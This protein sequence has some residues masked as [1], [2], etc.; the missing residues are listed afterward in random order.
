M[1]EKNEKTKERQGNVIPPYR[2][3]GTTPE[4]EEN[5]GKVARLEEIN[6]FL[7]EKERKN[8]LQ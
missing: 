4:W 8:Q 1:S 6:K 5:T 7:A 2:W 3:G